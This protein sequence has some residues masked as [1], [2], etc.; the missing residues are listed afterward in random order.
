M[1]A[2]SYQQWLN[3]TGVEWVA[4]PDVSLDYSAGQEAAL[5]RH[6]PSYL[7]LVWRNAHWQLWEVRGAP[8]LVTGPARLVSVGP[9]RIVLDVRAPGSVTLR[10]RYTPN[11]SVVSG[12]ACLT[13][14]GD[15]WIRVV[16]RTAG[17]IELAVSLVDHDQE[18]SSGHVQ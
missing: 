10:M 11:W 17:R 18:C 13:A 1:T 15:G 16:S 8:G 7:H 6:P 2:A 3:A 12:Q 14:T 5:L 9:D 4:L